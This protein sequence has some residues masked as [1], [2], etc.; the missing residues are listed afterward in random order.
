MRVILL[1]SL[2]TV[3][4]GGILS[5]SSEGLFQRGGQDSLGSPDHPYGALIPGC[6]P[7]LVSQ[8]RTCPSVSKHLPVSSFP[9]PVPLTQGLPQRASLGGCI[10][11]ESLSVLPSA[12]PTNPHSF[13]LAERIGIF[14]ESFF[15]TEEPVW[16][17]VQVILSLS[18]YGRP[19][20]L[21]SRKKEGNNTICFNMD[22]PRDY[23]TK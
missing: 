6:L 1:G 15:L 5:H 14:V 4:Q 19:R 22:E 18:E 9:C 3:A 21:F 20:I 10:H 11:P 7:H 8:N 16:E 12:F 2:T 17:T 13:I 23:P